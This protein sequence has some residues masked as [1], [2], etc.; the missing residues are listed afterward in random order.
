MLQVSDNGRSLAQ[1]DGAPFFYLGD[2]AWALLQRLDRDETDRYLQDRARREFTVVQ[3]VVVSEFDGLSVL[4]AKGD[5]PFLDR[6]PATP[7]ESYFRHVDWVVDRAAALKLYVALLPTWADKVGP[8]LWGTEEPVFTVVNAERYG[9]FLGRRYRD[10]PIIW[11]L[12]GDRT[13]VDE[14]QVAIWR[15]MAAG[16]DRGDGG[17]HLMTFHPQGSSSSAD[18]FH[19]EP[20]L[21]FNMLQSGHGARNIANH[22]LITRD[23]ARQPAKP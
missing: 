23:Y 15:A 16:L 21:D 1:T 19:D 4:N 17:R 7:N 12:G 2:T 11:V 8:R 3:T 20:W 5:L 9:E 18:Y 22:D 14:E 13:P 10:Q 6:N